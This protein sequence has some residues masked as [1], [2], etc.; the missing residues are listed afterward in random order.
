[1]VQLGHVAN[2][3]ESESDPD[4]SG[5]A[6]KLHTPVRKL[7]GK[8]ES[9]SA[10][11]DGEANGSTGEDGDEEVISNE[12][13]DED[14]D[15]DADQD[16]DEDG[17]DQVDEDEF[18]EEDTDADNTIVVM[19]PGPK[20]PEEYVPY[21]E[22]DTVNAVLEE[23]TGSDGETLYKVE[24]RDEREENV[25]FNRLLHLP[26]GN[27]ALDIFNNRDSSDSIVVEDPSNSSR[28]V[29]SRAG[30]RPRRP[31]ADNSF[32]D[33][34]NIQLSSD[35]DCSAKNGK[36]RRRLVN[37]MSTVDIEKARRSTRFGSRQPSRPIF[38]DDDDDDDEDGNEPQSGTVRS[39]GD[40]PRRSG[41][42]TTR[43]AAP[44]KANTL[45][46]YMEEDEDELAGNLQVDSEGS[47]IAYAKPK[48]QRASNARAAASKPN[49]RGRTQA[50]GNQSDDSS[51][52]SRERPSRISGRGNKTGKNMRERDVDEEIYADEVAGKS[53]P[54]VIS[55][56]EIY[57]PVSANSPFGLIHDQDCDVCGGT[58]KNSNKGRSDLIYCQGCSS[59][60]HKLCLGYRA[61]REQ[62][63]TKVGHENFVMQCRRCIGLAVKKDPL[64]PRLGACSSC[65]EPGP[66]CAAFS[67]KKTAKQEEK[68]REENNGDDPITNVR[69]NLIN[70]PDNVLF[71]C[72]GCQRGFHFEHLPQRSRKSTAAHN[73][74]DL[75][76]Q[77]IQEYTKNWQCK[78]CSESTTKLQTLVAWRPSDRKSYKEDDDF[79]TFREDEKEYLVKWDNSSY[80]QCSWMPG[81][82]VWGVAAAT[83]R[84]AFIR[85]D[86]G[87]NMSPKWTKEEAISEEYLRMEIIFDVEYD[88]SFQ[89]KSE[90][91]DKAHINDVVQVLVKFRGLT[92]DESVWE[93]PPSPNEADR[94]SDFV[95]AYN[96]YVMG[97]Y[98]KQSPASA[99]KERINAFRSLNFEKKVV[100]KKQPASLIGG[101]MM[102]HQMEGLNWL[103]FNFHRQKNVILADEMGLGKTIQVIALIATLVKDKPKCSP[104]LIVTP[105]S[106]C[107]NW[108]REIK[109]WAPDLR[110]VAYYGAKSARDMA[111]KYEMYP[112]GC[113]DLRADI[114]VTSY[115]APVDDSS[116]AFFRKVKWAGMIVDEGQR[117]KNDGNLLYGALTSLKI[118]FQVLLSGTPLQNNKRELFNLLQFL[119]E[120]IDA[121]ELDE[122][123]AE[124][125]KENLPELHELIRPF[126]L[127]R[128][129]LQVLKF[130][131]PMSQTIIPVSMSVVQK[132][133][134]KSIL[135]KNPELIKSIIGKTNK[136]LR[137]TERGNL[138]NILMQLRKCLCHPFLYSSAIE[139]TSLSHEAL[140]R[141]LIDAS[142]KFQLLEIMLPKLQARGHRVLIFSQFLKQ[143]DLVEDFLNGLELPFQRLDGT[144][145][146]LEKQKRIDAF[147][148]PNSKLFAFLLSTRAGG[149]GI[150]LAT[151]D[152]VIIMDPDFNPHQDIQ[153]LSRAHRIGQKKK[154]LVF[155]LVTK[156]SAEEQIV[157]VGRKKMALDQALIESIDVK[158]D[159]GDNLEAILR[160]G[161]EAVLLDDDSKDVYYDP[162]SVDELLDRSQVENTTNDDNTAESQFSHARVWIKDKG[163]LSEDFGETEAEP[164]APKALLWDAILK[165]RAND[166][167]LEAAK[168]MQTFGR[169]KRARQT[170]DY[171]KS[172]PEL[173]ELDGPDGSPRKDGRR[174]RGSHS[175]DEFPG[176]GAKESEAEESDAYED[177][178]PRELETG[179]PR[180]KVDNYSGDREGPVEI[181]RINR[182]YE[183]WH[184]VSIN[185]DRV[186]TSARHIQDWLDLGHELLESC[187]RHVQGLE[188]SN[189][190][191][192]D[193]ERQYR[194]LQE[195]IR[196]VLD[197]PQWWYNQEEQKV[198]EFWQAVT[199]QLVQDR[200][201]LHRDTAQWL[202]ARDRLVRPLG[203]RDADYS[204]QLNNYRRQSEEWLDWGYKLID[205]HKRLKQF[206]EREVERR[207]DPKSR[208]WMLCNE[209]RSLVQACDSERKIREELIR[210]PGGNPWGNG[211]EERNIQEHFLTEGMTR[212]QEPRSGTTNRLILSNAV[213]GPNSG[214][215]LFSG[216]E[217]GWEEELENSAIQQQE[218]ETICGKKKRGPYKKRKGAGGQAID[219]SF[220]DQLVEAGGFMIKE[221][222][223]YLE[224]LANHPLVLPVNKN[225]EHYY[226]QIVEYE[227]QIGERVQKSKQFEDAFDEQ[228]RVQR[229]RDAER[230]RHDLAYKKR[231]IAERKSGEKYIPIEDHALRIQELDRQL[232]DNTERQ[233]QAGYYA[234]QLRYVEEH[235]GLARSHQEAGYPEMAAEYAQPPPQETPSK[236]LKEH[237]HKMAPPPSDPRYPPPLPK[238]TFKM[239]TPLGRPSGQHAKDPIQIDPD[240]N[241][242]NRSSPV[243]RSVPAIEKPVKR[244]RGRPRGSTSS[245]NS[246]MTPVPILARPMPSR[247]AASPSL[248][249]L[250]TGSPRPN[251][252]FCPSCKFALSK[253]VPSCPRCAPTAKIR[254][255]LDNLKGIKDYSE[256]VGLAHK[257]LKEA[258]ASRSAPR[259]F[260]RTFPRK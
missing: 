204:V 205:A 120:S 132:Q 51:E 131:P 60:I 125:T 229:P 224:W 170:V 184:Q 52:W 178:D 16:A 244:K 72:R 154:V 243:I 149:V 239:S 106:T 14:A 162:A 11:Q 256:Q 181:Q 177:V 57:Q 211:Q 21:Q 197:E 30:K 237:L 167:A 189:Q 65:N 39:N 26:N 179:Q 257:I 245:L 163:D 193:V 150:N 186:F 254:L 192:A 18:E 238:E 215:P 90:E 252:Q 76:S 258:L 134:Y 49:K 175:D 255:M 236:V 29:S 7:S 71:R 157:Q 253:L 206:C 231:K 107:P 66:S 130:L 99:V 58:G 33:I 158:D 194:Y 73:A 24:Y 48:R 183:K 161:A 156:G 212:P 203:N 190:M 4:E 63:V 68:L 209:I 89:P 96:E 195:R 133:L 31:L 44:R 241:I 43:S 93:E 12:D 70:N 138:N 176:H 155:Q 74:D 259:T 248:A 250:S 174:T 95:S 32:V 219:S 1:M 34:S 180:V 97:R 19:V 165:Q 137:P 148:A 98:F 103:L 118:P 226:E 100:L 199:P 169:G 46:S 115:E 53:T 40:G 171:E 232:R 223:E 50:Q 3:N 75:R 128:T 54:K 15:Q 122:K 220:T 210:P 41:R 86:E 129:K 233:Q 88:E 92:Y 5:N 242:P 246:S 81:A 234:I 23:L 127:R 64:A 221:V 200:R 56:R 83:M 164:A 55:I 160:H 9:V 153:A 235:A 140:H 145:S 207:E 59:S 198:Q 172:Q 38:D 144:V 249:P 201:K 45:T 185:N 182:D 112:N 230:A 67:V 187:A 84:K 114:V 61:G 247:L 166:A 251:V 191:Q 22:D 87:A 147:N 142:S 126:F 188:Q 8:P 78:Q 111:M 139:E 79:D 116:R 213:K 119:D 159:A 6:Q 104:F 105:N 202:Q 123:Y 196:S 168:N 13:A 124:L 135:A 136:A 260:P 117:L 85:R 82:W 77:R 217:V 36:K 216:E 240:S 91:Y 10:H 225:D 227:R 42:A 109:K 94:W 20:N 25:T 47:D 101:E 102:K 146:T 69:G 143:L 17:N 222:E 208:Y 27:S 37:N 108:R 2:S 151:A 173:M 28:S 113:S 35:G 228:F 80:F 121:A 62:I 141:N 110:V 218:Q 214:N 152:T